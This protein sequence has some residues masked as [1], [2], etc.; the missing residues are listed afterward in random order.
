MVIMPTFMGTI[1]LSVCYQILQVYLNPHAY[2]SLNMDWL[3]TLI[4]KT[5]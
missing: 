3:K 5:L 2:I 4:S 1:T